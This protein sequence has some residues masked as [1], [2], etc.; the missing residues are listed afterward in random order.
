M[1]IIK[2]DI[3]SPRHI[4]IVSGTSIAERINTNKNP[5]DKVLS[6]PIK[7]NVRVEEWKKNSYELLI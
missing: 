7:F 3:P 2:D 5:E 4:H 1:L 6:L